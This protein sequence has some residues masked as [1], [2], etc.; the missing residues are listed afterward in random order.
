MPEL[1]QLVESRPWIQ[2]QNFGTCLILRSN[3]KTQLVSALC[4]PCSCFLSQNISCFSSQPPPP[5]EQIK[6]DCELFICPQKP[7]GI[8]TCMGHMDGPKS[9]KWIIYCWETP[10]Q[11]IRTLSPDQNT[12]PV[13]SQSFGFW[14]GCVRQSDMSAPQDGARRVCSSPTGLLT[15][16]ADSSRYWVS[17]AG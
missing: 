3:P 13:C 12:F 16:P 7:R 8:G 11:Q 15:A 2:A 9:V 17:H 4:L 14:G 10:W 1:A 6:S 5:S